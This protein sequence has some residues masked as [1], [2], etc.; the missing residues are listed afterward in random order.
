MPAL[1]WVPAYVG[2][3]S[4][5]DDPERQVQAALQAL[6]ELP[7]T[8]RVTHSANLR[9]PALGPQPQPEFVNAVAG[10]LTRLAPVD[11]LDA[12]L[13]IEHRQGRDRR[14]DVR[15]GPRRIDLDLLV[16]GEVVLDT[17]RLVIPHPGIASRNFVL[18]PLLEIAPGLRVPGLGPVRRLVAAFNQ[19]EQQAK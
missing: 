16:Y 19:Q 6:S 5:L 12:L 9:N 10:L 1:V 3:G 2:I 11:L 15:W 4:N 14:S 7:E 18:F 17:D 13:A 8:R